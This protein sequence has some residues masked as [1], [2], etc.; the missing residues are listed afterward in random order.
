MSF[1]YSSF[2]LSVLV[3]RLQLNLVVEPLHSWEPRFQLPFLWAPYI[4]FQGL[5][6]L[7]NW[8]TRQFFTTGGNGMYRGCIAFAVCSNWR[9][10][11]DIMLPSPGL[12]EPPSGQSHNLLKKYKKIIRL[13]RLR[14]HRQQQGRPSLLS[15]Q[16]APCSG[17]LVAALLW[18]ENYSCVGKMKGKVELQLKTNKLTWNAT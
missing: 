4:V 2:N 14:N 12:E 10:T 7:P 5:F 16:T 1:S 15:A 6:R 11:M 13:L 17:C 18:R 3:R 9:A 8:P